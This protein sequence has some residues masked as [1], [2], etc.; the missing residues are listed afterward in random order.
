[1]L[2]WE[3]MECGLQGESSH[4]GSVTTAKNGLV[5][6]VEHAIASRT[7]LRTSCGSSSGKARHEHIHR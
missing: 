7:V 3:R 4:A 1:M 6:I 2:G 5:A